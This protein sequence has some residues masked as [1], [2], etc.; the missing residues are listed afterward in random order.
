MPILA[1]KLGIRLVLLLGKNT[2]V[3]ASSE[4]MTALQKVKVTNDREREDGFEL[5]FALSKGKSGEFSLLKT[6]V[7]DPDTRVAIG[8][9]VGV[10]QYP[11]IDGVITHQQ[12]NSGQVSGM[13]QL[14][15]L[16]RGITALLDLKEEPRSRSNQS[17]SSIVKDILSHYPS[18]TDLTGVET[19]TQQPSA[20]DNTQNQ[21]ETDLSYVRRLARQHGFV[22]YLEPKTLGK[23]AAYWGPKDKKMSSL[24]DLF[25]DC[26]SATN[27]T[28]LRF[29]HDPLAPLTVESET[30]EP[31]T[32][33]SRKIKSTA[34]PAV[35][36]VA[37]P[38]GPRRT[39]RMRYPARLG[40][41]AAQDAADAMQARAPYP[42]TAEGVL[43]TVRYGDVLRARHTV[44]VHGM[45]RS[46]DG[47]YLVQR[48]T[49]D[50]EVGKYT[51][52]FSLAR[53]GLEAPQ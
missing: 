5:T 34:P 19:T 22:F 32:K 17:S 4:V 50:I 25:V 27:V 2:P 42:V 26:G 3:P 16:G 53:M 41:A 36:A 21:N 30:I 48:V 6:G 52:Q 37:R 7:V 14:T 15:I 43:D 33:K 51:Q 44:K 9:L 39:V 49:H 46:Y 35:L 11:L 10:K 45:G 24:S 1:S 31:G 12:L 8:V 20:K 47:D 13:F 38:T 40:P 23:T 28:D 18:I 29:A